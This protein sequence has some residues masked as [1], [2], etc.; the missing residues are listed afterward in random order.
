ML[1]DK[2]LYN[3]EVALYYILFGLTP[4]SRWEGSATGCAHR[5]PFQQSSI[6]PRTN[7]GTRTGRILKL[8]DENI[9]RLSRE[10]SDVFRQC[11]HIHPLDTNVRPCGA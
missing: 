1:N 3:T 8:F 2:T 9:G 7:C 5:Y 11:F 4:L 6:A 10:N